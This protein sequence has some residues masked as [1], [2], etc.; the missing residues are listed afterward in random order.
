MSGRLDEPRGAKVRQINNLPIGWQVLRIVRRRKL[1]RG[2]VDGEPIAAR[3]DAAVDLLRDA[4]D[5]GLPR[6]LGD[7]AWRPTAGTTGP[8]SALAGDAGTV[9]GQIAA[10][11]A[12]ELAAER[13][14]KAGAF[15]RLSPVR[16]L[17]KG[18]EHDFLVSGRN[19]WAGVLDVTGQGEPG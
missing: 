1:E 15:L 3:L 8:A 5:A 16:N 7:D 13:Q 2:R 18:M 4:W 10:E 9:E 14:A 6:A 19:A 11:Q 12:G 17:G